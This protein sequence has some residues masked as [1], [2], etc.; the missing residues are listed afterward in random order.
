M[1]ATSESHREAQIGLQVVTGNQ[2]KNGGG[3][4]EGNQITGLKCQIL[5]TNRLHQ[6]QD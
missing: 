3:V 5:T 4:T 2:I 6:A 1:L